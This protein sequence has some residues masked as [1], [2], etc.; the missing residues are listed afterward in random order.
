[1]PIRSYARAVL[2]GF[3]GCAP[4]LA[5]LDTA[6]ELGTVFDSSG[7]VVPSARVAVEYQGTRATVEVVTDGQGNSSVPVLP[8]RTYRVTVSA[9]GFKSRLQEGIRLQVSDRVRLLFQSSR[10]RFPKPSP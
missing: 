4:V 5:Q 2:G 8:V 9:D 1:M 6:T 3:L 10:E 7:A